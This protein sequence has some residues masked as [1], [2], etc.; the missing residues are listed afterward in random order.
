MVDGHRQGLGGVEPFRPE[1]LEQAEAR[2]PIHVERSGEPA[3]VVDRPSG[4]PSDAVRRHRVQVEAC[5]V[6]GA[7]DE[8]DLRAE[9][10]NERPA[11]FERCEELLFVVRLAGPHEQQRRMRRADEV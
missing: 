2:L 3:H 11:L 8:N 1:P 6:V 7:E 5:V 4:A 9:L 10:R